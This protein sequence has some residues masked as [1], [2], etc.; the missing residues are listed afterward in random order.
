MVKKMSKFGENYKSTYTRSSGT[1][2]G[3]KIKNHSLSFRSQLKCQRSLPLLSNLKVALC[4]HLV[5]KTV[6]FFLHI[7][8][9]PLNVRAGP[10]LHASLEHTGTVFPGPSRA[11][12]PENIPNTY[13][14]GN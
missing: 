9:F 13:F 8:T 6:Y 4:N 11:P 3:L 10:C 5:L 12:D 14:M 7:P 2:K 1:P